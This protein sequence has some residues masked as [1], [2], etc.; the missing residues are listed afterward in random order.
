MI[1]DELI[2]KCLKNLDAT[3]HFTSLIKSRFYSGDNNNLQLQVVVKHNPRIKA[4]E[5]LDADEDLL[6]D[7]HFKNKEAAFLLL[8]SDDFAAF[9]HNAAYRN[10][11]NTL[12][13]AA[14]YD[15]VANA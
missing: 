6:F 14:C 11:A 4:W 9:Y 13:L 3:V 10:H 7:A 15:G 5:I 2:S 12:M 1:T 8:A